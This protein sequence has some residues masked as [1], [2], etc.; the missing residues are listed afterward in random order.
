MEEIKPDVRQSIEACCTLL[1]L[2]ADAITHTRIKL[3]GLA[4]A[5]DADRFLINLSGLP[6]PQKKLVRSIVTD[7]QKLR[8][9][10]WELAPDYRFALRQIAANE[11]GSLNK[12]DLTDI[13]D[14][15]ASLAFAGETFVNRLHPPRH[16]PVDLALWKLTENLLHLIEDNLGY[17]IVIGWNDASGNEPR[18]S[19]TGAAALAI[20]TQSL[21]NAPTLTAVANMVEAVRNAGANDGA[22]EPVDPLYLVMET[23]ITEADELDMSLLPNRGD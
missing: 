17:P 2:P 18:F 16:R 9:K 21:E 6:G 13:D 14:I 1:E 3:A 20:F 11:F 22:G 19:S 4:E 12:A 8:N 10:V 5:F 7:V 15:L 23:T